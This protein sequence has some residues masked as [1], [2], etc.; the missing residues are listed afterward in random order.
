MDI[1]LKQGVKGLG[2]KNDVVTVKP[3]YA[4]NYLIPQGLAMAASASNV[5][6]VEETKRQQ[7][8]KLAKEIED[9][10]ELGNQLEN[11]TLEIRTK[12]GESGKIFGA[13]TPI[14]IA[15]AI[16]EKGFEVD[17]RN[18]TLPNDLKMLGEYTVSV[19]L[20]KEVQPE[21]KLNVVEE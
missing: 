19:Y 2:D 21:I 1:I 13:V 6:A 16:K 12:A 4:R 5:K 20:H 8:R 15:E 10:Q 14:Q 3:G 18:I 17:R 7:A 11:L 9:A